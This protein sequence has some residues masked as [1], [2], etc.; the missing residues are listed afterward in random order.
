MVRSSAMRLIAVFVFL[1]AVVPLRAATY[2]SSQS[3]NWSSASTWAA[4]AYRI[5]DTATVNGG[6]VVTL[7][8]AVTVRDLT[9]PAAGS[10]DQHP[11]RHHGLQLEQRH[12]LR[13]RARSMASG[14]GPV[15][16][17]GTLDALR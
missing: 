3:G 5:G 13:R 12:A 6:H 2:S 17:G 4:P 8:T 16:G 7:D 1:A 15:G 14:T 10:R 9:F 11:R